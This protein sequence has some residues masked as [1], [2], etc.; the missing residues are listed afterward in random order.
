MRTLNVP[1]IAIPAVWDLER[2]AAGPG[3]GPATAAVVDEEA[4]GVVP[5]IPVPPGIVEEGLIP[6]FPPACV[7]DDCPMPPSEGAADEVDEG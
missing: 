3:P 7:D 4:A 1:P 5:V 6:S 2:G